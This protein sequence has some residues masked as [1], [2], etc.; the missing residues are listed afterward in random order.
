M[1]RSKLKEF[2]KRMYLF[3]VGFVSLPVATSIVFTPQ[4]ANTSIYNSNTIVI[5]NTNSYQ[6]YK[7]KLLESSSFVGGYSQCFSDVIINDINAD[8]YYGDET[9]WIKIRSVS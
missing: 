7:T 2:S 8:I 5:Q 6:P 4:T 9:Q 1:R 3:N